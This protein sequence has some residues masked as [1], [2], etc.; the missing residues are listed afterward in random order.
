MKL[1][2][3]VVVEV[4]FQ[5]LRKVTVCDVILLI[6]QTLCKVHI[7]LFDVLQF[8]PRNLGVATV[9]GGELWLNGDRT[10]IIK[11]RVGKVIEL[12]VAARKPHI[13]QLIE[14]TFAQNNLI[15]YQT[16]VKSVFAKC[17]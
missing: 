9:R 7:R 10:P 5:E 17:E 2:L 14:G 6:R 15:E 1:R 12:F 4:L 13:I 3:R 8:M 16:N 11:L